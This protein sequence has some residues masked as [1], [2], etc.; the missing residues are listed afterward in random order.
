VAE[1]GSVGTASGDGRW[2][3][4]GGT[5]ASARIPAK[6]GV[7]LGH[8]CVW[9]LRWGLGRMFELSV[10]HGHERSTVLTGR[11]QWWAVA[12]CRRTQEEGGWGFIGRPACR[13]GFARPSSS[14]GATV[15]A[16]GGGVVGGGGR[17]PMAAS[18]CGRRC[19]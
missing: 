3:D 11:R 9:E 6:C 14:T 13:G 2:R 7:E 16:K 12:T 10:G 19:M 8:T 4:S 18:A 17:W 5:A 1:V 15:G